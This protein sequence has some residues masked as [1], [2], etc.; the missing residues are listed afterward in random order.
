[1]IEPHTYLVEGIGED[2]LCPTIDFS[3]IDT[4]YQVGD[5]ESFAMA[6]DLARK[7]GILAGGSS[8]SVVAAALKHAIR[9]DTGSVMVIILPDSGSNYISKMFNDDWMRENGF[10]Q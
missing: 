2:M 4:I 5:Q 7:E 1:M 3:V 8:G 10:L 6:R 9:L